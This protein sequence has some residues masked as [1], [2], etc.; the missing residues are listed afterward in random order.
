M[1][2]G[3]ARK[4]AKCAVRGACPQHIILRTSWV[5][6]PYG[7]NFLRTMLRLAGERAELGIV[8]DQTGC[9]T[10]A[11]D[12]AGAILPSLAESAQPGF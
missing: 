12:L 10:A 7:T 9:P 4:R 6:S 3:G 5:F 8:D 11:A 2:M 1:S